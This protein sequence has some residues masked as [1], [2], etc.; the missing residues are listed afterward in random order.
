MP[1]TGVADIG[2]LQTLDTALLPVAATFQNAAAPTL[3]IALYKSGADVQ[4]QGEPHTVSH[5]HISR[6]GLFVR[7]KDK[8]SVVSAE[9][10]NI[11]LTRIALPTGAY[12]PLS[13]LLSPAVT[14]SP[15]RTK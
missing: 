3:L 11:P 10:V 5:V 1:A 7:L 9:E 6:Q 12:Q 15:A 4:Y 14:P 13:R 8:T 2:P